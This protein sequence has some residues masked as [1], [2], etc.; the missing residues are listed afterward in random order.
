[1]GRAFDL[2]AVDFYELNNY[3]AALNLLTFILTFF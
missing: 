3:L 2:Y 1:M